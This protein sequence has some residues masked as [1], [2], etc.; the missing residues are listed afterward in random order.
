MRYRLLALDLDGTALN[1]HRVLSDGVVGAVGEAV[2]HGVRVVLATGRRYRAAA[3]HARALGLSGPLITDNGALTKDVGTGETTRACFLPPNLR[4]ELLAVVRELASPLVYVD[5]GPDGVDLFTERWETT[6]HYQRDYLARTRF[7]RYRCVEDVTALGRA[8]VVKVS[9]LT[10][11]DTL[12]A[13]RARV[14]R[15]L[16]QRVQSRTVVL[17]AFR[18]L[19]LE[20]LAPGATK[21]AALEQVAVEAG[22]E[23]HE[24]AAVG[25]DENDAAMLRGAGLGI[26]VAN[27][28]QEA[29]D[30]ADL[31]V[32]SNAAGG[33]IEAV[34]HVLRGTEDRK[35]VV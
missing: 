5:T 35:S 29:V 7:D 28:A 4:D 32:S 3:P 11:P 30:A 15:V 1:P 6:H 2:A 31:V 17:P 25:D 16:G 10:D 26:A 19:F 22:I 23:P 12:T 33:V 27:A 9:T 14:H 20:L 13:L 8:D 21:W 18:G 24:I 34:A